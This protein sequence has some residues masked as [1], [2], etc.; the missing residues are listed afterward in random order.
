MDPLRL[1]S[2]GGGFFSHNYR[3]WNLKGNRPNLPASYLSLSSDR[4]KPEMNFE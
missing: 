1:F 2:G 3:C 4:F